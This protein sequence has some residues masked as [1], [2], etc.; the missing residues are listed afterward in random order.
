[1][2]CS[3]RDVRRAVRL[4]NESVGT[5]ASGESPVLKLPAGQN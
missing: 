2:R 1:M 4:P 5:L 3:M